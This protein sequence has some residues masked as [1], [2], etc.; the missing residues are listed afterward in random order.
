MCVC[1]SK[2]ASSL[3]VAFPLSHSISLSFFPFAHM[4]FFCLLFFWVPFLMQSLSLPLSL[5]CICRWAFACFVWHLPATSANKVAHFLLP[6]V[7]HSVAAGAGC[8]L[9]TR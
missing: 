9:P 6:C 1:L 8:A 5:S 2:D 4:F 3:S 7:H